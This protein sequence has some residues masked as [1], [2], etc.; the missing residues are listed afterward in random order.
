[1]KKRLSAIFAII[2][3]VVAAYS[4]WFYSSSADVNRNTYVE[5]HSPVIGNTSA[6]VTIVEFLTLHAK[7]VRPYHHL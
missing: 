3:L 5:S 7:P 2:G 1:M 6:P 4:L